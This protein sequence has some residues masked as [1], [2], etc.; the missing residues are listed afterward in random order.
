METNPQ[1]V[2]ND[3]QNY[4]DDNVVNQVMDELGNIK[5]GKFPVSPPPT[6]SN[7]PTSN[8]NTNIGSQPIN[9]TPSLTVQ[10]PTTQIPPINPSLSI[11]KQQPPL[12][13][14]SLIAPN[15]LVSTNSKIPFVLQNVVSTVNLSC[16]LD[17]KSIAL[18]SR[19]SEYNPKRFA[20]VIM[21]IRDPKAT[22]LI[23]NSG[24]MVCTG[25]KS[26]I[27]SKTAAK[28]FAKIIE[29][30]GFPVKFKEFKI[31]NIVA[32]CAMGFPIRLEGLQIAHKNFSHYEPEIFPGLVYRMIEPKVVLL[33]FVTGK[34]VFTGAKTI[35]DIRKALDNIYP[36]L[37]EFRK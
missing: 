6:N 2:D 8:S 31:Q 7:L 26:V 33:I 25:T 28:K 11:N 9:F 3:Y 24:K 29:K 16:N 4:D 34:V 35:D 14:S 20:A 37:Q 30:V 32:S 17:L 23:F 21:K 15:A 18:K 22:A 36:V 27:Q 10:P 13:S 1:V 19:N 5:F 12:S